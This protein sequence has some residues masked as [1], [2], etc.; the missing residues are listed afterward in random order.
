M[1]DDTQRPAAGSETSAPAN[2]STL[3]DQENTSKQPD[4][5]G[6]TEL[7]KV[8]GPDGEL[9]GELQIVKDD[10]PPANES[11]SATAETPSDAPEAS[12]R[13]HE[14]TIYSRR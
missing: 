8:I 12:R 9:H 1:A 11:V 3:P 7:R 4:Q 2:N 14:D 6:H 13:P 5:T 10:K